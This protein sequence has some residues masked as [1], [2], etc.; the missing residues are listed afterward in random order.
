VT[1]GAISLSRSPLPADTGHGAGHLLQRPYGRASGAYLAWLV[2]V[3]IRNHEPTTSASDVVA[4]AMT[5]CPRR[6]TTNYFRLP[7]WADD[8]YVAL[9]QWGPRKIVKKSIPKLI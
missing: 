8:N 5:D 4:P 7:T 2:R 1:R 9:G 6:E 3:Q